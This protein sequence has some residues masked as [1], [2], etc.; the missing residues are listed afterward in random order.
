MSTFSELQGGALTRRG[1]CLRKR[2]TQ[3]AAPSLSVCLSVSLPTLSRLRERPSPS[4]K[5]SNCNPGRDCS[6]EA[7][8]ADTLTCD[9]HPQDR[10]QPTSECKYEPPVCGVW[11]QQPELTGAPGFCVTLLFKLPEKQRG[12]E[13]GPAM[14]GSSGLEKG[15]AG[16]KPPKLPKSWLLGLVSPA[17]QLPNWS[18]DTQRF[19]VLLRCFVLGSSL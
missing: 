3:D 4:G 1:G 18:K 7:K 16:T 15:Y 13:R 19:H 2:D 14:W 5:I 10:D 12:E 8:T 11:L 6:P 9:F 17:Q